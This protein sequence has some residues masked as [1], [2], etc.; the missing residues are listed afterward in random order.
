MFYQ[1]VYTCRF[2]IIYS[3]VFSLFNGYF[4]AAFLFF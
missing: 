2:F 3:S 4:Q 1:K